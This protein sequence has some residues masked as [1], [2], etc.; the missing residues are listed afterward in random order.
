MA[1]QP[2]SRKQLNPKPD[3][4]SIEN[5]HTTDKTIANGDVTSESEIEADSLELHEEPI[6]ENASIALTCDDGC[7]R[8]YNTSSSDGFTYH[9]S[10][11]RVGGRV[12]SVTWSTDAKRIYSGSSDGCGTLV[13][14]DSSGSVQFWDSSHGTLLQAHSCH[15]GDVNALAASPSHTRVFSAGSDGHV[16]NFFCFQICGVFIYYFLE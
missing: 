4:A 6:I 1:A 3:L 13:S 11:P 15:K 8:I 10:L 16:L 14:A 5:G 9:K 12:L 2:S 7:V